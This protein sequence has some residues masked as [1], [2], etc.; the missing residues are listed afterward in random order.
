M[1]QAFLQL[2]K[3]S[4]KINHHNQSLNCQSQA[5]LQVLG[6]VALAISSS[7]NELPQFYYL[8]LFFPLCLLLSASLPAFFTVLLCLT[9]SPHVFTFLFLELLGYHLLSLYIILFLIL[10]VLGIKRIMPY[11]LCIT[12]FCT[13][14]VVMNVCRFKRWFNDHN[15]SCQFLLL[16][17]CIVKSR[18]TSKIALEKKYL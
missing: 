12:V 7:S 17:H 3:L 15:F 2:V 6:F 10:I 5:S 4:I 11:L 16:Q 13:L 14:H 9:N 18:K 1:A 8:S